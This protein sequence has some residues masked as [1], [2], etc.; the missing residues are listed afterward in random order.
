MTTAERIEHIRSALE[1][2]ADAIARPTANIRHAAAVE[3][4]AALE[5]L[6]EWKSDETPSP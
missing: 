4:V 5:L 1:L 3:I 6:D 2:A